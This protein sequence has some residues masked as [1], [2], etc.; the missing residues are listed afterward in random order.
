MT[1]APERPDL[2]SAIITDHREV[3]QVFT[4]LAHENNPEIRRQLTDHVIAELVRHSVA[5]EQYLYPTAREV[6]ADGDKIADHEIKEHAEAEQLMKRL[7]DVDASDP[8]FDQLLSELMSSIRHHLR[9]EEGDLLPRLAEHCDQA[10]LCDLG[11]KFERAKKIAPTHPH[12][13]APDRP[14][15]NKILAP[16]AGL[17]DRVRDAFAGRST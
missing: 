8:R 16:G 5:E 1:A 11:E 10:K 13:A 15:A 7:E 4:E 14:P 12:P 2:I 17:I 9:D 3:E 6:L